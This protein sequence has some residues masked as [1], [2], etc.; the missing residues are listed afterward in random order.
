MTPFEFVLVQAL[1]GMQ[2]ILIL[3]VLICFGMGQGVKW[4]LSLTR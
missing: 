3:W 2:I 1:K 4:I